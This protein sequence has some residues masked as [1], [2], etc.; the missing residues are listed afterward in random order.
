MTWAG[1]AKEG[2]MLHKWEAMMGLPEDS[3]VYEKEVR[4]ENAY[5]KSGKGCNTKNKEKRNGR[6]N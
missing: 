4:K 6:N 3:L 5:R 2:K 1:C